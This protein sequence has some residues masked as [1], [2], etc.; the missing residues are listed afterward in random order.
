MGQMDQTEAL[1]NVENQNGGENI[2]NVSLQLSPHS[3]HGVVKTLENSDL[4]QSKGNGNNGNQV[5]HQSV[6]NVVKQN[7]D[8]KIFTNRN[9]RDYKESLFVG[10]AAN[11]EFKSGLSEVNDT[12]QKCTEY[13]QAKRRNYKQGNEYRFET[14]RYGQEHM[15]Y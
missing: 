15:Y 8:M 9:S 2:V 11:G 14:E 12:K 7:E 3:W 13:Q 10:E 4:F 5:E 6:R 1:N